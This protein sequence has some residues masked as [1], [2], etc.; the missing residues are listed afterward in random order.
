MLLIW[1]LSLKFCI[2]W[3]ILIWWLFFYF[4]L[5]GLET[6]FIFCLWIKWCFYF[7]CLIT[8][9]HRISCWHNIRTITWDNWFYILHFITGLKWLW[10]IM[11]C[12][13]FWCFE[14]WLFLYWMWFIICLCCCLTLKFW[15]FLSE[16]WVITAAIFWNMTTMRWWCNWRI[17]CHNKYNKVSLL[18]FFINYKI[19]N[20]Y[21]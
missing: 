19:Y 17:L 16:V 1:T 7:I 14:Y 10:I 18:I 20:I 9:Y 2:F 3:F 12:F 4:Y 13:W 8:L 6:F 21:Y 11:F 5:F 15:S